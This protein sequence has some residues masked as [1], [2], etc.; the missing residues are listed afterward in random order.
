MSLIKWPGTAP[1]Y[2]Q[3]WG[4]ATVKSQAK[5][6]LRWILEDFS[7]SPVCSTGMQCVYTSSQ[8][9]TLTEDFVVNPRSDVWC[10]TGFGDPCRSI[11]LVIPVLL[12]W[13]F[14]I[15]EFGYLDPLISYHWCTL[16]L[17]VN[18]GDPCWPLEWVS[19]GWL[20]FKVWNNLYINRKSSSQNYEKNP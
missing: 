7:C 4:F 11:P 12:H 16:F 15:T 18:F 5:S 10:S 17:E 8:M 20:C 9:F 3:H 6:I 1:L 13:T 14:L 2:S 19:H